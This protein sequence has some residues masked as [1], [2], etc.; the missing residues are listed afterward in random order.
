MVRSIYIYSLIFVAMVCRADY[1]SFTNVYGDAQ[2]SQVWEDTQFAVGAVTTNAGMPPTPFVSPLFSVNLDAT[3]PILP[4]HPTPAEVPSSGS[5][6]RVT[7]VV[8]PA[9]LELWYVRDTD[10]IATQLSAH[11]PRGRSIIKTRRIDTGVETTI[12]IEET[13]LDTNTLNAIRAALRQTKQ[14]LLTRESEAL[15]IITAVRDI[16]IKTNAAAA[17]VRTGLT[18]LVEVVE[19]LAILQRKM[20]NENQTM[21]RQQSRALKEPEEQ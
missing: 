14:D 5:F 7:N 10:H 9:V 11:D 18:N 12:P 15:E 8:N 17:A 20:I 16:D 21:R 6:Y 3:A 1:Y 19:N 13:S 2:F 4:A